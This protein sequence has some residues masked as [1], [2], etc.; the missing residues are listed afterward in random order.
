M[1]FRVGSLV[2]SKCNFAV[3][4]VGSRAYE[5]RFNKAARDL[6]RWMKALGAAELVPVAEGDVDRG[7][8]DE[9]FGMWSE[10]VVKALKGEGG[11]DGVESDVFDGF[12]EEVED[13]D[14][15][16]DDEEEEGLELGE[17][18]MEDIA[19]KAPSRKLVASLVNGEN[20]IREK[21]SGNGENGAREMVTPVI[22]ASLQKQVILSYCGVFWLLFFPKYW[23]H[24]IVNYTSYYLMIILGI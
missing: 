7:D 16:D 5:G 4:G 1:D 17:V 24:L 2:L 22:R 12:E 9:I 8:V 15:D 19:G 3:F 11:D 21:S 13:D 14:N 10:R 6:S 20:G 18:D 23:I